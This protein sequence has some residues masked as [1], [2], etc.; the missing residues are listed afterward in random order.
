[1]NCAQA[2]L[3]ADHADEMPDVVIRVNLRD[4]RASLFK[5]ATLLIADT[6]STENNHEIREI[7]EKRQCRQAAH[8]PFPF[9]V[10]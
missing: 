7:H 1:M 8:E 9:R 3:P 6:C 4:L 5:V 10:F 2:K